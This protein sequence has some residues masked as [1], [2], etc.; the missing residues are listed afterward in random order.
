MNTWDGT[1]PKLGR[2]RG[3]NQRRMWEY[4]NPP[5]SLHLGLV[6]GDPEK[7]LPWYPGVQASPRDSTN[8]WGV[9]GAASIY[10][11][12]GEREHFIA[13]PP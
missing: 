9:L 2:L 13:T 7:H 8:S 6:V 10:C 12:C 4:L 3:T 1:R 11:R 5:H